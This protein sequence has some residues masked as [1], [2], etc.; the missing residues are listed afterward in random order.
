MSLK[1]IHAGHNGK[2][3]YLGG[4]N[5]APDTILIHHA[6][7]YDDAWGE[8]I[9]HLHEQGSL[10]ECDCNET[11]DDAGSCDHDSANG[12]PVRADDVV[13]R[14]VRPTYKD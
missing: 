8:L 11:E 5:I 6:T 12:V 13:M 10:A 7:S 9:E 4:F 1:I 14:V 3:I 2:G